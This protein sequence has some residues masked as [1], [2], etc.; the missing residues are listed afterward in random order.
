M[1]ASEDSHCIKGNAI[2]VEQPLSQAERFPLFTSSI[3]R[4][5]PD[6]QGGHTWRTY[7]GKGLIVLWCEHREDRP[8]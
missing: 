3:H 8:G 7:R 5:W 4:E 6:I 1:L 2:W